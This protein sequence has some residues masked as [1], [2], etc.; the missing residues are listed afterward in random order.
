MRKIGINTRATRG[1][2]YEDYVKAISELGFEATFTGVWDD[3]T[4]D[5]LTN[6]FARYGIAYEFIHS[7][8]HHI[9]DMWL[10]TEEGEQMHRE[11]LQ[12]IDL[13]ARL[14]VPVDVIHLSSGNTPPSI[15]ELGQKRY[16]EL[17]EHAEKKNVLLAFENLRKLANVAWAMETFADSPN[18]GFC[19]DCGHE[20]CFTPDIEFMRLFGKKLLCTHIHD[21]RGISCID[22]HY[23]PFDGKLDYNRFAEHIRN[24]GYTGTLTLEVSQ[25]H[26]DRYQD[27]SPMEFLERAA[28]AAKKLRDITDNLSQ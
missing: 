23:L 22:D 26:D 17:V 4:M 13:C 5:M 16:A 8:F 21:N 7:P 25:H 11:I 1:L 3:Q 28:A 2:E 18:V 12:S 14:G 9:N 20:L 10:D 6:L 15:S 19:W 27:F 24:S